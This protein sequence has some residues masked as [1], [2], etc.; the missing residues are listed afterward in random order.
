MLKSFWIL[1][2]PKLI[3]SGNYTAMKHAGT[4]NER[5]WLREGPEMSRRSSIVERT[6]SF[7]VTTLRKRLELSGLLMGTGDT[8]S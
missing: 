1:I 6:A 7:W 2:H 3:L 8:E 4:R 5:K